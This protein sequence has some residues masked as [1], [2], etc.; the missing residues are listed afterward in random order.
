[1]LI[2]SVLLLGTWYVDLEDRDGS[3]FWVGTAISLCHTIGLHRASTYSSMSPI[4][5]SDRLRKLWRRMWWAC[6]YRE[7][8]LAMGFGRP[9]RVHFEDCDE[10]LPIKD[11]IMEDVKAMP[12]HLRQQYLPS[13]VN[14]LVESWVVLV[15][16]GIILNEILTMH[17]RPRSRLPLPSILNKQEA[18][19]KNLRA[20]LPAPESSSSYATVHRCHF[21]M[22]FK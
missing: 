9:V 15:R 7:S 1:M 17:Y 22:Y 14:V 8:W 10:E 18:D 3:W 4:P 2:Q 11:D 21:E 12:D 20:Q 16:L 5:F 19:I 6:F 13:D